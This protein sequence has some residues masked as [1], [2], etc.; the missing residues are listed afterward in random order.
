MYWLLPKLL[1]DVFSSLVSSPGVVKAFDE[2]WLL[3]KGN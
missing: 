3:D 2:A 1:N